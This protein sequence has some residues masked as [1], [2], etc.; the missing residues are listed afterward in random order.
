MVL[1]KTERHPM[2]QLSG[3]WLRRLSHVVSIH[4]QSNAQPMERPFSG[5]FHDLL[6]HVPRIW[7]GM[8]H[9]SRRMFLDTLTP[10]KKQEFHTNSHHLLCSICLVRKKRYP[11]DGRKE[12]LQDSISTT[13]LVSIV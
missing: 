3:C 9:A 10:T 12:Q 11:V 5:A 7:I 2:L 1:T 4:Q 8:A 6:R 13:A